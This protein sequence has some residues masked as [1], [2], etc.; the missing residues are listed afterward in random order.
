MA[1]LCAAIRNRLA[2][3]P[4]RPCGRSAGIKGD[5]FKELRTERARLFREAC[6]SAEED[7]PNVVPY[8]VGVFDTVAALGVTLPLRIIFGIIAVSAVLGGAADL[9]WGLSAWLGGSFWIWFG[10]LAALPAIWAAIAYAHSHFTWHPEH[11][12]FYRSSWSMRFY[13]TKLHSLVPYARHAL[14]IDESRA[15]FERVAWDYDARPPSVPESM[16]QVWFAG[17]HSDVG[18]SY[19]ENEARLSDVTL[20]WMI[21]ELNELPYPIYV[22]DEMLHLYPSPAGPQHD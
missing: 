21:E 16:S 12:R 20:H 17:N 5:P 18:G 9:G 6:G 22:H 1:R 8:F 19:V 11:K 10:V 2:R 14:A 3:W 15:E 7:R 4:T 13:D